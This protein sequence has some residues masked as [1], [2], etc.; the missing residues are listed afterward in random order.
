MELVLFEVQQRLQLVGFEQVQVDGLELVVG[1]G[2]DLV[3]FGWQDELVLVVGDQQELVDHGHQEVACM[4]Q[5][6]PVPGEDHHE[7]DV[8]LDEVD[9]D[10]LQD[11]VD[12]GAYMVQYLEEVFDQEGKYHGHQVEYVEQGSLVQEVCMEQESHERQGFDLEGIGLV[13]VFGLGLVILDREEAGLVEL[14]LEEDGDEVQDQI[15]EVV[16]GGDGRG[17]EVAHEQLVVQDEV[18]LVEVQDEVGL[19]GSVVE[20]LEDLGVVDQDG[21]VL[22]FGDQIV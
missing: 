20:V 4:E 17:E 1:Q 2:L 10:E 19:V 9:Q 13:E 11:V 7:V 5:G 8:D 3:G 14:V 12:L 15:E 21:V 18:D 16:F 6:S 22:D